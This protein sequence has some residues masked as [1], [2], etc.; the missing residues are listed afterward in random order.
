MTVIAYPFP[1]K[2][3]FCVVQILSFYPLFGNNPISRYYCQTSEA[4]IHPFQSPQ[5]DL[6]LIFTGTEQ[7]Y[8]SLLYNCNLFFLIPI[9]IGYGILHPMCWGVHDPGIQQMLPRWFSMHAI[10]RI[11]YNG[12]IYWQAFYLKL[13]AMGWASKSQ[14]AGIEA[15]RWELFCFNWMI[16]FTLNYCSE[17]L[18]YFLLWSTITK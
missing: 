13:T 11:S 7:I 3:P 18:L 15:G 4:I 9:W 5:L 6:P 12:N 1:P 10:T 8:P 17:Y 2:H 16:K 14:K